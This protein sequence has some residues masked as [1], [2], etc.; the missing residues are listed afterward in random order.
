MEDGR[1]FKSGSG[2]LDFEDSDSTDSS[3]STDGAKSQKSDSEP[4]TTENSEQA[5]STTTT[6]SAEDA[7][8]KYPYFVR[9]SSVGDERSNRMEIHV[10]DNVR[11]QETE[12]LSDL[13]D[14]LDTDRVAKTDARE[15]A[16]ILARENP[17][18]VARLMLEDG[19][20][21]LS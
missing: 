19:Y 11:E 18:M 12:F 14:E 1:S 2:T 5:V 8:N 6:T 3:E 9:R 4:E 10:R 21:E 13:A 7:S 16:L 20:G 15:Y 17:E